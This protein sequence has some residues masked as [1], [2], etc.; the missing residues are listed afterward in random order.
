MS[1]E[2]YHK[3]IFGDVVDVDLQFEAEDKPVLD[4]KGREFNIFPLT[5]TF[6][7]GDKKQTWILYREAI[8]AGVAAERIFFTLVWKVKSM[9]L[10][11]RT[12]DLEKLSEALVIGYHEARRG[13]DEIETLIEKIILAL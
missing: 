2:F 6:G 11:K 5:N 1:E 13:K 7:K 9:L 8:L 12:P 4:K 10:S 3:N